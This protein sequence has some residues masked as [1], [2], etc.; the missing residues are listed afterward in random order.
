MVVVEPLLSMAGVQSAFHNVPLLNFSHFRMCNVSA[1][2]NEVW[3]VIW[4][5]VANEV[6]K[7][8]N[9]VIFKGGVVDVVEVFT[10]L[11]L[12]AWVWITSK[13]HSAFFFPFLIGV[14]TLLFVSGCSHDVLFLDVSLSALSDYL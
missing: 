1:S 3:G 6:L 12:K 13:S 4:I 8:R 11:Q 9:G 2:V 5:A 10:L 7:H 14:L